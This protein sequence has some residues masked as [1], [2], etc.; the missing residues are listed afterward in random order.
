MLH[1]LE[2]EDAQFR[3]LANT[4]PQIAWMAD[5]Q[6]SVRWYND[7]WYEYTGLNPKDIHGVSWDE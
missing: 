1:H 4:I 2:T 3:T 6:G 7:R 5:P